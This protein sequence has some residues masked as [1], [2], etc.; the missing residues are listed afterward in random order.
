MYFIYNYA[1]SDYCH[2]IKIFV[3]MILYFSVKLKHDRFPDVIYDL[4]IN[5]S[6]KSNSKEL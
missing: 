2:N 3:R 5:S 4:A 1:R 6:D